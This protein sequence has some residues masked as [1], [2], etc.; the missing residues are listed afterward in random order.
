MAHSIFLSSTF[1]DFESERNTLIEVIPYVGVHVHCAAREALQPLKTLEEHL[2]D[3]I[4]KSDAVVLLVGLKYGSK[5][6]DGESWTEK[7]IR[8]ALSR[9]K[10]VFCYLRKHPEIDLT[11]IDAPVELDNLVDF[12]KG[13]FPFV[14][15]YKHGQLPHL[16]AMVIRDLNDWARRLDEQDAQEG[17]NEIPKG[18]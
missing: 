12:I 16:V 4:D 6:E 18:K 17:F 13:R 15:R 14:Q 5:S 1:G 2:E 11:M 7:E 9:N 8:Y 10:R 3:W